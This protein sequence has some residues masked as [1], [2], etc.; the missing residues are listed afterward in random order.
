MVCSFNHVIGLRSKQKSDGTNGSESE[1][2]ST[3]EC[4][5]IL[6]FIFPPKEWEINGNLWRQNVSN[7]PATRA[8]I[9]E[10]CKTLDKS[11]ERLQGRETGVCPI[12]RVLYAQCF[13]EIIRQVTFILVKIPTDYLKTSNRK[14]W[15][16]IFY[17]LSPQLLFSQISL[18]S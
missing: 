3:K 8:E 6:N 9:I 12:R 7:K 2:K 17:L 10:L 18:M 15:S 5:E 1:K 4:D 16:S 11:L 13:D 14:Y